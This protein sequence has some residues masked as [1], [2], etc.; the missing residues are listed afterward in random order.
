LE[1]EYFILPNPVGNSPQRD[2]KLNSE[3]IKTVTK[4]I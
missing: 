3:D 1:N 4:N 2:P